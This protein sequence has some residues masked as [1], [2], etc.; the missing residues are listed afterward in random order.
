MTGIGAWATR[1]LEHLENLDCLPSS[2]RLAKAGPNFGHAE[3][4][5][6]FEENVV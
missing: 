6:D 5:K 1:L 3:W 4:C 2:L